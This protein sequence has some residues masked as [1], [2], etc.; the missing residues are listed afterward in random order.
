[1]YIRAFID[2]FFKIDEYVKITP[3]YLDGKGKYNSGKI[4]RKISKIKNDYCFGNSFVIFCYDTDNLDSSPEDQAFDKKITDYCANNKYELV[5]FNRDIE[6]VFLGKRVDK[7][8]KTSEATKFLRS[9]KIYGV[10]QKMFQSERK[11]RNRSNLF[12]VINNILGEND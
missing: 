3:I 6:E 9:R 12:I 8:Q 1:M 7:S 2:R 11:V 4:E 5:F 10:D